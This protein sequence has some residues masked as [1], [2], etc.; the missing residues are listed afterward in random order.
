MYWFPFQ[1]HYWLL[2]HQKKL[3]VSQISIPMQYRKT[4]LFLYT[5]DSQL[6]GALCPAK[7]VLCNDFVL[8]RVLGSN[9]QYEHGAN[10]IGV[11]DEVVGVG[12][13]ADI[14]AEPCDMG[15]WVPSHGTAHVTLITL[16]SGV[17]FQRDKKLGRAFQVA[18]LRL[19]HFHHKL[20]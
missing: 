13:E 16:W 14:I 18:G 5:I 15:C 6:S 9:P 19:W 10:T 8:S 11:G 4:V 7:E 17:H 20:F 1:I 2:K 3:V 12:V